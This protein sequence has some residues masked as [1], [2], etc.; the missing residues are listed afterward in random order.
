MHIEINQVEM[1]L[2]SGHLFGGEGDMANVEVFHYAAS[3]GARCERSGQ[4]F[5]KSFGRSSWRVTLPSVARSIAS[6][7]SGLGIRSE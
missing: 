6:A 7:Y 4:I 1:V 2:H 5:Q 3:F